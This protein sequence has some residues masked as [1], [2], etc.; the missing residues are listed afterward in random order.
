MNNNDLSQL[1]KK[2][3]QGVKKAIN[4]AIEKHKKLGESIAIWQDDQVVIL[5]ADQIPIIKQ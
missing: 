4:S 1:H 3:D 5:S 2:I